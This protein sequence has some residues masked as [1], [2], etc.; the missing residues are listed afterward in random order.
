MVDKNIEERLEQLDKTIQNLISSLPYPR[1]PSM[2]SVTP[3]PPPAVETKQ[4]CTRQVPFSETLPPL[5]GVLME[6]PCPLTG[7]IVEVTMHWPDGCNGLVDL[8]FGHGEVSLFPSKKGEYLALNDA[9]PTYSNLKELVSKGDRLWAELRNGDGG[10][11]HKPSIIVTLI[12][13]E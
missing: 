6:E 10:N 11:P 5:Q 13:V 2:P 7:E 1:I 3:T 9:T 4:I 12:G 8:Q